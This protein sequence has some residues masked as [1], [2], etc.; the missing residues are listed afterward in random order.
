MNSIRDCFAA[1]LLIAAFTCTSLL[2]A[3]PL[4]PEQQKALKNCVQKYYDDINR[5]LR[6][7]PNLEYK[8]CANAADAGYSV[9]TKSAGLSRR[10]LPPPKVPRGQSS[11][12]STTVAQPTITPG[13][14][15]KV[16]GLSDTTVK[17]TT[18]SSASP[19]GTPKSRPSS[20]AD[21]KKKN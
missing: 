21:K 1:I 19:S 15:A 6:E 17:P 11:G 18:T 14:G 13:K 8:D 2:R 12:I 20:P 9:C 7:H 16:R 3:E 10:Q 5:C 4:S